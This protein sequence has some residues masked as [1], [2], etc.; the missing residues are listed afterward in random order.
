MESEF[1]NASD[2]E[3]GEEYKMG[4]GRSSEQIQDQGVGTFVSF[5]NRGRGSRST[6]GA[7]RGRS[8]SRDVLRNPYE[9]RSM[10]RMPRTPPNEVEEGSSIGRTP[11]SKRN[12]GDISNI[13][14]TER[15]S[16][17]SPHE[18]VKDS[19]MVRVAG[20]QETRVWHRRL[21]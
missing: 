13:S 5:A 3:R 1:D 15:V 4:N 12:G 7:S 18:E 8:S 14:A 17:G 19:S 10:H 9:L 6:R 21:A 20:L 2:V 11:G 16:D